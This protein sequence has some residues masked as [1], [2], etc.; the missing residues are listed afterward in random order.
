MEH[1]AVK[2]SDLKAF[3]ACGTV[4]LLQMIAEHDPFNPK[5]SW[6]ELKDQLGDRVTQKVIAGASHA[7]FPEQRA[8][9]AEAVVSWAAAR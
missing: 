3:S 2:S 6:N 8:A 4:P 1:E 9:V 7:L 5:P